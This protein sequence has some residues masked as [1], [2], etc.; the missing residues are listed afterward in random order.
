PEWL[1]DFEELKEVYMKV[2]DR[3]KL[4]IKGKGSLLLTIKTPD[5]DVEYD[6]LNVLYVPGLTDTLLSIGEIAREGHMAIFNGNAVE[7]QFD[8]G[9]SLQV[10]RKQKLQAPIKELNTF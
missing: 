5:G 10:E 6:A 9:S 3:S 4:A 8:K 2:G 7:V 1:E